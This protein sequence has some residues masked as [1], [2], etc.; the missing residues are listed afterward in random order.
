MAIAV[1]LFWILRYYFESLNIE[2]K[3]SKEKTVAVIVRDVL[4]DFFVLS[5]GLISLYA[6]LLN[7]STKEFTSFDVFLASVVVISISGYAYK[8]FNKLNMKE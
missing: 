1:S 8:L 5:S 2:I 6:L 3:E 7:F 4:S